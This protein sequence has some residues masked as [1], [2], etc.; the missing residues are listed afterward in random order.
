MGCVRRRWLR[1]EPGGRKTP[2]LRLHIHSRQLGPVVF[3]SA[4]SPM[5]SLNWVDRLAVAYLL[6][7]GALLLPGYGGEWVYS[8]C[9][10]L[11]LVAVAG[12]VALARTSLR[13]PLLRA[14]RDLYPLLLLLGLYGEV[15]LLVQLYHEPPGFDVLVGKWDQWMFGFSP[16]LYFDQWLN[17]PGWTELF[18]FLYLSYYLLLIGAFLYVW[19]F[20][21]SMLHRFSFVVTGMFISFVLFFVLFPV[22][23]PLIQPDISLTTDG[24]FPRVVAW[25]YAPLTMN[26]I[27]AGAFPSSHVGMSV[28][29]VL[30]LA[31]RSW[32]GRIALGALVLGIALSTVYGRFHYAIDAVAG[33]VA[34]GVLYL[35]WERLYTFLEG[36]A[37]VSAVQEAADASVEP[38]TSSAP[39]PRD[40]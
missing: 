14:C 6:G 30:L 20:R 3:T 25:V 28:G 23:G 24:L 21:A 19:R 2:P 7:A 17:G 1:S 33:L 10:G 31:P 16:H 37:R 22:A 11:H 5:T 35:G 36:S 38:A 18:H 29:I 12:I 26:G 40:R 8:L 27:H 34:G 9:V 15:D 4:L 32:W 39:V 13:S